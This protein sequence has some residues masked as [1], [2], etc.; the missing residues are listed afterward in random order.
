[1]YSS[2]RGEVYHGGTVLTSSEAY[3]RTNVQNKRW[4][5]NCQ[6]EEARIRQLRN[7]ALGARLCILVYIG[8]SFARFLDVLKHAK[9]CAYTG[10]RDCPRLCLQG[11]LTW[12]RGHN[13]GP[14]IGRP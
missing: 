1:M 2:S 8:Q 7:T 5:W 12:L 4:L 3:D 10:S 13:L 9:T 11:H 6:D 14:A